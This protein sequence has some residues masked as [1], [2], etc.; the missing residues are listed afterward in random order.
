L[1]PAGSKLV[2]QLALPLE[3]AVTMQPDR[4]VQMM[5]PVGVPSPA[6]LAATVTVQVTDWP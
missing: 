1:A 4:F 3:S 6:E 5:T 2:V